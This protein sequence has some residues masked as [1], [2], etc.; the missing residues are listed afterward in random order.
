V[1]LELLEKWKS[2]DFQGSLRACGKRAHGEAAIEL[3]QADATGVD[4]SSA[5][6]LFMNSTCYD[7]RLMTA[8]A[9]ISERMAQGSFCVTFTKRLP[10]GLWRVLEAEAHRMTWGNAT[11]YIHRKISGPGPFQDIGVA[12]LRPTPGDFS[13]ASRLLA[14]CGP[15]YTSDRIALD[16]TRANR[17]A[18]SHNPSF[19]EEA[20]IGGG[21][22]GDGGA[23]AAPTSA[24]AAAAAAAA[25]AP[26]PAAAGG[27]GG[28]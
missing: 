7:E 16:F 12:P 14:T 5:D 20:G 24:A 8:L 27:G 17:E 2:A 13:V 25:P 21:G 18:W 19:Q 28:R 15:A 11:I 26:A 22:G 3:L 9:S 10:S 23:N 4:W 6:V 1:S